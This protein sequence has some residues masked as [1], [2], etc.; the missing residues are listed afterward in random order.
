M[1]LGESILQSYREF[2]RSWAKLTDSAFGGAV[3]ST[4][5]EMSRGEFTSAFISERD[6]SFPT[7][8]ER[9]RQPSR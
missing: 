2:Q 3:P 8:H 9:P 6:L 5:D 4:R 1:A 7:R